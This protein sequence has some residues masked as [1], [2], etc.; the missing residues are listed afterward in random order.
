MFIK[1]L[2]LISG[3]KDRC[4]VGTFVFLRIIVLLVL[5]RWGIVDK[6]IIGFL[7]MIMGLA[8]LN[9]PFLKMSQSMC[10]AFLILKLNQYPRE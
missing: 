7:G 2:D 3:R 8:R 5:L 10:H 1:R 6:V 4:P 9:F